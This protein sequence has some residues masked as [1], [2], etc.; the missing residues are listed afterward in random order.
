M[1]R[2]STFLVPLL[3]LSI[4]GIFIPQPVSAQ[5]VTSTPEPLTPAPA[6]T[7]LPGTVTPASGG[8]SSPENGAVLSGVVEIRG[9]ALSAWDLSFSYMNDSTGTWFPLAHSADPVSAGTLA[10]WDTTT[11]SD[12]LYVLRL[13]VSAADAVQ[14]FRVNVRIGNY[15]PAE[16]AT[17]TPTATPASTST[18]LPVFTSTS[19]SLVEATAQA[20]FTPV[21]SPTMPAPLPPNPATLSPQD[22]AVNF[23]KG[24][25]GVG[26]L[27]VF[28]GLLLSLGRKLRS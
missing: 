8:I 20:T 19:T 27:F 26:A 12:G 28:F 16:T 23:G 15:Y 24:A 14:V 13:H 18:A 22:V 6:G 9:T 25:L 17:S 4:L 5:E 21:L 2:Y 1:R 7:E 11:I 10:T 3:A